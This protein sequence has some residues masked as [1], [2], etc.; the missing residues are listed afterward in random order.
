MNL[1]QCH[2]EYTGTGRYARNLLAELAELDTDTEFVVI[3]SD[4]NHDAYHVDRPNFRQLRAPLDIKQRYR[5]IAYEQGPLLWSLRSL[6]SPATVVWSP[7]DVPLIG[8]PG[9]QVVTL[10]DLRRV[11]LPEQFGTVERTYYRTMMYLAARRASHLLT[12]SETSRRDIVRHYGVPADRV[13]VAS[14]AVD[15]SL[16]RTDSSDAIVATLS[17]LGFAQPFILF[18]G[19]QLRVK[20]P[21]TLVAGFLD[22]AERNHDLN[23][24]L[25]GKPGNATPDIE[26]LLSQ[27]RHR[28]RVHLVPWIS[29]PDLRNVLSSAS[30]FVFP[31]QYEGFGIPVLEAMACGAPVI[32]SRLSC[33]PEVCGDAAEYLDD[34]TPRAIASAITRVLSDET[35][36]ANLVRAGY[37]NARRYS[38]R[39]SAR[40]VL[41]VLHE[42][43]A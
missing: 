2:R 42:T 35:K 16:R 33:M 36:R 5:R 14:N 22:L 38:W 34:I 30:A 40:T 27:S 17:R 13:T 21:Q 11:L 26:H 28:H 7:N 19:Q 10:H 23:L 24:V 12:V 9:K 3:V 32:T 20:S 31:T 4:D 37:A 25:V 18:V 6:A 1:L 15:P 39:D 8:W 41:R 43:A 29:D